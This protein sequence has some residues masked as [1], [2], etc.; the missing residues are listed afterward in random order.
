[1]Q[2]Y[3]FRRRLPSI[4]DA[5]VARR[6]PKHKPKRGVCWLEV[7][8]EDMATGRIESRRT[9]IFYTRNVR[10]GDDFLENIVAKIVPVNRVQAYILANLFQPV[11]IIRSPKHVRTLIKYQ[12]IRPNRHNKADP[13]MPD[14]DADAIARPIPET[15]K[16][17]VPSGDE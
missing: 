12:I 17:E 3:P 14:T 7:S 15:D 4:Y 5:A 11:Y 13:E 1:M 8:F 9:K 2:F 10:N 6:S 16:V